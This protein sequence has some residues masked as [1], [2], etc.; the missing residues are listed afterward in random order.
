MNGTAE[1]FRLK[2]KRCKIVCLALWKKARQCEGSPLDVSNSR[3]TERRE[4]FF[5]FALGA[6]IVSVLCCDFI[7]QSLH[8]FVVFTIATA[9]LFC[10]E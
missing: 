3:L 6:F 7:N 5:L 1:L 9:H 10:N 8:F 2:Y 4:K